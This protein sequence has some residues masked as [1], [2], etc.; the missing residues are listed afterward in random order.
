LLTV[1]ALA[2]NVDDVRRFAFAAGAS[3]GITA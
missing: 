1:D 2:A 3:C